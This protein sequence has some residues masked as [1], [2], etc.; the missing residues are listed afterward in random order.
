MERVMERAKELMSIDPDYKQVQ[1]RHN[2]VFPLSAT[3]AT[4][5]EHN[6]I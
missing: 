3:D 6:E 1:L 4:S 2:Q 5:S